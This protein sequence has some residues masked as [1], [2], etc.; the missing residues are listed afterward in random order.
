MKIH[1]VFHVSLLEPA[2]V[3]RLEGQVQ[4]EEPPVDTEREKLQVEEIV[5]AKIL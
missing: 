4:D 5:D 3:D 1:R 2:A